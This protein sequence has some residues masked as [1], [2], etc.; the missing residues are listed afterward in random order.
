MPTSTEVPSVPTV[1]MSHHPTVGYIDFHGY[2]SGV[3]WI[4]AGW[5]GRPAVPASGEIDG[6]FVQFQ[7]GALHTPAIVAYFPR[8]DVGAAGIGIVVVIRAPRGQLLELRQLQL[9]IDGVVHIAN[10]GY[11]AAMLEEGDLRTRT[12]SIVTNSVFQDQTRTQL[13]R[14]LSRPVYQGADTLS[15]LPEP[16]MMEVDEAIL[17]PPE[18]ILLMGWLLQSADAGYQFRLR[19]GHETTEFSFDKAV[20]IPRQ[21]VVDAFPAFAD[22]ADLAN[23]YIVFIPHPVTPGDDVYIEVESRSGRIGF[24]RIQLGSRK[25]IGAIRRIMELSNVRYLA[26][27]EA[28]DH[29]LGPAIRALNARRLADKGKPDELS[30]GPQPVSPKTSLVI[31]LYGRLD[32]VEYQMA[33]FTLS[34]DY[35]DVDIIYVM[36]DPPQR[37]RLEDL[38]QSLYARFQIP[39]RIVFLPKNLGFAPA[40]NAGLDAA[41]GRYVCF[42]NSDIFPKTVDWLPRLVAHLEDDPTIG[43]SGPRLLFEDGSVQHEG[44]VHKAVRELGDWQF[45]DHVNKGQRP[46]P[47]TGLADWQVITGACMVMST[48]LARA[49]GGFDEVFIVGDFEDA[50]LCLKIAERGLRS[51]VDHD[52][53]LFHLERKS[54]TSPSN[55]WRMNLTLFNAWVYQRRWFPDGVFRLKGGLQKLDQPHFNG[56]AS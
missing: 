39:F 44:C 17:C 31:P 8:E 40:C 42:L 27:D 41:R 29:V 51:V 26:V 30:Y 46:A 11:G 10:P 3:G 22:A 2:L 5:V 14:L 23:G 53:E 4:L 15:S 6:C 24:K 34:P 37:R 48:S 1:N 36:D 52:V 47:I 54:Q 49:L 12:K 43:M 32:F 33:M 50:D 18:G 19:S 55:H 9:A 45:L 28:F 25:G 7:D 20:R 56:I 16:I 35:R 21:D 13:I 38:S